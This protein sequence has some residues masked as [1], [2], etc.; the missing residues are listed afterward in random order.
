LPE[1]S[2]SIWQDF[3]GRPAKIK[4]TTIDH[5]R[6]PHQP[7][8]PWRTIPRGWRSNSEK[9]SATNDKQA[10]D[11]ASEADES[12]ESDDEGSAYSE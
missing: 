1:H 2:L 11:V 4:T 5:H 9:A 8:K 10:E 7:P 12:D 6:R 3:A